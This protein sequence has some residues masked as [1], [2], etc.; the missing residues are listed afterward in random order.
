MTVSVKNLNFQFVACLKLVEITMFQ[1]IVYL[2]RS[3]YDLATI[4]FDRM[5]FH[6]GIALYHYQRRIQ[7]PR[8]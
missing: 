6:G 3:I 7:F 5:V 4:N 8:N 2:R 1:F